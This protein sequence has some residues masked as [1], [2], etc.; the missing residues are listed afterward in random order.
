MQNSV[1]FKIKSSEKNINL[2]KKKKKSKETKVGFKNIV[3]TF[4]IPENNLGDILRFLHF[5]VAHVGESLSLVNIEVVVLTRHRT[6]H[7]A[8][9]NSTGL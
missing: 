3:F 9:I 7:N 1:V 5:W 6:V 8:I 4:T 2:Y